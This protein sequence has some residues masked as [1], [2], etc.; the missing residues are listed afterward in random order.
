M[1]AQDQLDILFELQNKHIKVTAKMLD[2]M[3]AMLKSLP[4]DNSNQI[5]THLININSELKIINEKIDRI[6]SSMQ[7]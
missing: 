7:F 3:S 2:I 6:F 4:N 5:K 1:K